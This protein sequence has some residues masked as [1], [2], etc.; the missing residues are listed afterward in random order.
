[1]KMKRRKLAA[2]NRRKTQKKINASSRSSIFLMGLLFLGIL[3]FV[4]RFELNIFQTAAAEDSKTEIENAL[5]V[6]QEFFGASAIVPLP[7]AQGR[8]NLIKLAESQPDNSS[9]LEKLA[10][11]DE[12]LNDFEAAEKRRI[13]LSEIDAAKLENLAA[14]YDRRAWFE[15]EAETLRKILSTIEAEKRAGVFQRL[16]NLARRHDLKSY[17]QNDFFAQVAKEN[18]GVY[19]IFEQLADN[20]IEEENYTEALRFVRQVKAQFPE[21]RNVLLEKEINILLALNNPKEAESIY[22]S[23]F[24]P[25]WSNDEAEKFYGFLNDQNRLRAYGAELKEKFRR[26][27]ADFDAGIRLAL[28][29]DHDYSYG[30]DAVTPVVSRLEQAKKD[31]TTDELVTVTR[32]LLKANEGETASRFLYTLYLRED[33]KTNNEMQAKILYQLFE[34]FSDAEIQKLPLTKGDLSFYEDAAKIDTNP[35]IATGILSLIFS[36]TNPRTRL[37]EQETEANKYF[38]RAAAYRIFLVYKEEFPTSPALAQMYLDIVRLYTATGETEIAAAT[39]EEFERRYENAS[40]YPAVAMKLADAFAAVNQREKTR[41]VYQKVLDYLGKEQKLLA[42]KNKDGLPAANESA[43]A[44]SSDSN[45]GINIPS[46]NKKPNDDYYGGEQEGVF[47][48]YL[49]REGAAVTYADVLEK[50]VAS[51]AGEKKTA[52]ILALYSGEIQKY[53]NE[54]WLY[55]Q[56]LA[57]L[58]QT[59]LTDEELK[60]YQSALARFQS[61]GWQDKLARFFIRQKR[62]G[63]FAALAEDLIG[64]LTDAEAEDFLAQFADG[65]VSANDFEQRLYLKLYKTAHERFPH[66]QQFVGGLLR[67]YKTNKREK[68]WR[69][70]AAEYYF[71]SK[72]TRE[73]FLDNLAEKNQLREFLARADGNDDVIYKLFRADA[74]ARLSNYENAIAAYRQLNQI[75]PNT[76][77]FS[78]RLIDFTR[79]FGQ[80]NFELL[81]ESATLARAEANFLPSSAERRTRSGEIFAELGQYEKS[82]EEWEK[83]TAIAKGDRE[84]YLDAATVY[85]DYFQYDDAL[86][87]I[88]KMREKFAD[89]T[90]YAFE[91]GAILEARHKQMEAV[92]EYVKALDAE[93]D[94]AQKE[95]AR[96]RLATL[97]NRETRKAS[98]GKNTRTNFEK[99]IDAAFL[100]ENARRQNPTFLALGY[101]ELLSEI[102]HRQKAEITLNRAVGQSTNQKFIEAARDFYRSEENFAGEQIALKRLAEITN[103]PREKIGYQLQLAESFEENQR[104]DSAKTVLS[105][106]V[107]RF[108]NNYG[109]LIEA[110][111]FYN[112]LGFENESVAVLQNALPRSR[113]KFRRL[114]AQKLAKNLIRLDRLDSAARILEKLHGEDKA[115]AEIFNELAKIYVRLN[116]GEK[117]RNAFR[118]TAAALR[119]TDVERRELDAQIADLRVSMIDAFTRLKD[120]KSAIE[121]HIEII[122]REPD[123]EEL[124]DSAIRY[125]QRYGGAETLL[126]YYQKTSAEA[127]KDYRWNVVL[128]RIC[129]ARNDWENAAKNYAAA[130]GNQPEM[131]ELYVSL[132]D[133]ELKRSNFD[134]ALKNLDAALNLTN[135]APEYVGKKIE[136][137]KK[138]GRFSEIEAEMAKLPVEEKPKPAA[139]SFDEA[140]KIENTE[141]EKARLLY[142]EAFGKLLENPLAAELRTADIA[143]YVRLIRDEEPLDRINA[144]LWTLRGKLVAK[145][146][147]IDSTEAGE[148]RKR[149]SVLDGALI[150]SVGGTAKTVGTNDERAALHEYLTKRIEEISSGGGDRHQTLSLVQDL[151]RRAGFGDV[152]ETIL[153]KKSDA[154]TLSSDR[155]TALQN[156]INFY[157]ERGAYQKTFGVLEKYESDNLPLRAET[158][159][160]INDREKELEALRMIY[161]K[162]GKINA[163]AADGNIARYLEILYAENRDELKSLTEK[164]SAWQLQL[165]NFLL[166]KGE[167]ELVHSAVENANLPVA[168]KKSRRAETSLALREFDD[169]AARLFTDAL[170]IDSIGNL[171]RQSPDKKRFLIND[172]WFRLNREYGEWLYEGRSESIAPPGFLAAMIENQPRNAVEQFK[173]GEFYLGKND[174]RRAIEHLRLSLELDA[175][176][177]AARANLGAALHLSGEKNLAETAF[178]QALEGGS[179]KSGLTFFETLRKRSLAEKGREKLAPLI[180]KFL[181]TNDADNSEEFQNLIRA[182]AASFDDEDE[183]AM[184][185][186]RVLDRRKTDVSLAAMLV[187]ESLIGKNRQGEFYESLIKRGEE[188]RGY[189]Y[190]YDF[191][192]VVKRTWTRQDAE[193]IFDQENDYQTDKPEN[194]RLEW[195]LKFLNLLV[196]QREDLK[197]ENLIAEIEK[198]L[199]GRYALP[200]EVRLAKIQLRIRA[201]KFDLGEAERFIGIRVSDAATEIKLPSVER[202][203][204]GRRILIEE[205]RLNE[206]RQISGSFFA[207]MLA[208]E[209]FAAPNFAGFARVFFERGETEKALR[210]LQLMTDAG[211][212]GKK[213]ITLAEI[214]ALEAVKAQTA[215]AAKVSGIARLYSVSP[216]GALEIAAQISAEFQQMTAAENFRRRLNEANPADANNQIELAKILV[217]KGEKDEAANLLAQIISRRDAPRTARWQARMILR[218]AGGN[219]ETGGAKFDAFALFCDGVIA[220]RES[221]NE[222]ATESFVESLIAE[223]DAEGA[224][225]RRELIKLYAA[226]GKFFAAL[227]LA[228]TDNAAKPDDLLQTLSDAAERTGDFA[229]AIDFERAK[230]IVSEKRIADLQTLDA[231]RNR[232]ATDFVVDLENT[233]KL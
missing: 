55:E 152:E 20:L 33:F 161:W 206:A 187:G 51:F 60:T 121:Q 9:V 207:R 88:K 157:N 164:S 58:E 143:G 69:D 101:A 18:A 159:R 214:A 92:G 66:S 16:I 209:Q 188:L 104:P 124:T 106:L 86:R 4:V 222:S 194:E 3:I 229:R 97:Y 94:K 71:E 31:W 167:R 120:F 204:E 129:E 46:K 118:E 166:G 132:A 62:T 172:D 96:N 77:E 141:R 165:I 32:L 111:D 219:V 91:T 82:R 223:K 14:F 211:D 41:E 54:E 61:R 200:P 212:E 85:W 80:K 184:Y 8:E 192:S 181:E 176:D 81:N 22:Q 39:L 108:P 75:Y 193:S 160:L 232:R 52:E 35:G 26:N 38:N 76:P 195:Q 107:G 29:Q 133:V 117:L 53:P 115:D 148:A 147:E 137:L 45:E 50:L 44:I 11:L 6:Q 158:A 102:G 221:R 43:P 127:F 23:A 95:K 217:V 72:E 36:D 220:A 215:D 144:R 145:A 65:K 205:N 128:A 170:H 177:T 87:T 130:I 63:E 190:D 113:G 191:A 64:K 25:F 84:I 122:N 163:A 233:K 168:W 78:G 138:A 19:M 174:L 186:R 171:V 2:K 183:K 156:L 189:D 216:T 1:M 135:D 139:N 228:E 175:A 182:V 47:H 151:S 169:A 74:S 83:L 7:T 21:R 110:A 149:I 203:N 230:S 100:R 15:K 185:F 162:E 226:S 98:D 99:T 218:D 13:H 59:N 134:A 12:K 173:L 42:P 28:Y 112:R 153:Q 210:I 154:A 56:R 208:L 73:A 119:Q 105:N 150:E 70:L 89:E 48:D 90:L 27:P 103:S 178:D 155:Q 146:D 10:E 67:F 49:A 30:N 202:F 109:V 131:P 34:M 142:R 116:A 37:K 5:Y 227:K 196:E 123:D 79:S 93:K 140:K 136:A 180:V 40:D 213:E 197:A 225:A 179:I 125:V 224:T 126:D 114:L 198:S 24:D 68:E 17:L 201:G 57:W 231:A 199:N